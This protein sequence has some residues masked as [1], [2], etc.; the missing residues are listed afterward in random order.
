MPRVHRFYTCFG[1]FS[2]GCSARTGL[3]CAMLCFTVYFGVRSCLRGRKG[4]ADEWLAC[5]TGLLLSAGM[6]LVSPRAL[7][8]KDR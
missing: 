4:C 6:I 5:L 7:L 3:P 8:G 1:P 2:H